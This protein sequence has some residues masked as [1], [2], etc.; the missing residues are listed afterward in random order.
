MANAYLDDVW[1]KLKALQEKMKQG[2]DI[3]AAEISAL[4]AAARA[5][6]AEP[7]P[8]MASL[9]TMNTECAVCL[10]CGFWEPVMLAFMGAVAG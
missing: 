4:K 7:M 6:H 3:S 5:A 8:S 10:A 1:P 2:Q 9:K